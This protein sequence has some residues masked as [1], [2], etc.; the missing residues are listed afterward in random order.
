MTVAEFAA[1]TRRVIARE[2]FENFQPVALFLA[3]DHLA[4]L[5]DIP[6]SAEVESAAMEWAFEKAKPDEEVLIAF[7]VDDHHFKVVRRGSGDVEQAI[8]PVDGHA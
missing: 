6:A 5:S 8:F 2:G 4:L 3:R 1:I 7:K